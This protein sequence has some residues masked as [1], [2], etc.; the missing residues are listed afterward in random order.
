MQADFTNNI[1]GKMP[2][3]AMELK[4]KVIFSAYHWLQSLEHKGIVILIRVE[5]QNLRRFA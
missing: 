4:P 1:G 5:H 2:T 3:I